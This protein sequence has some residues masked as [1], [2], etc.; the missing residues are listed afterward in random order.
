MHISIVYQ[1]KETRTDDKPMPRQNTQIM[2]L[3]FKTIGLFL[4]VI[5]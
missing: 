2:I 1:A 4:I 5:H 3:K